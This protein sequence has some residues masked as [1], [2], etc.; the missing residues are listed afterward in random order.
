MHESQRNKKQVGAELWQAQD[1]FSKL[2]KPIYTKGN[3]I[4][5]IRNVQKYHFFQGSACFVANNVCLSAQNT[6]KN[7]NF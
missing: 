5:L 7:T 2:M 3:L 1:K 6:F 4:I